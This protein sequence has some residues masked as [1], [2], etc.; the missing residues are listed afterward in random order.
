MCVCVCVCVCLASPFFGACC[1]LPLA[2]VS[3]KS[4]EGDGPPNKNRD[5]YAEVV[6]SLVG[7]WLR[8]HLPMQGPRFSPWLGD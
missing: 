5:K 3:A 2:V 4:Q 6:T 8:I 7:Q 1:L